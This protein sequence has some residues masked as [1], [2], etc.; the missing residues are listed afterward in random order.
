MVYPCWILVDTGKIGTENQAVGL[1][2]RLGWPFSVHPI[3]LP[4]LA[5]K[6][7]H[8]KYVQ[9]LECLPYPKIIIAAGRRSQPV[10]T[11]FK[12]YHP[13]VFLIALLNP[14]KPLDLFDLV[15]APE[16][17]KLQ[18]SNV[19]ST[20]G[21]LHRITE[22]KL[23]ESLQQENFPTLRRPLLGV[24][25]GGVS[26]HY[27]WTRSVTENLAAHFPP[28][29]PLT[30][31]RFRVFLDAL[32]SLDQAGWGILVLP[33]RRTPPWL[34][35][36][37]E[38]CAQETNIIIKKGNGA[39]NPYTSVLAASDA[40]LVTADSVSMI[41]EACATRKPVYIFPL[42][43][44]SKKLSALHA[45]FY[46]AERARP[47]QGFIE[48]WIPPQEDNTLEATIIEKV[49]SFFCHTQTA[50]GY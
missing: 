17:D 25:M 2:E 43:G 22:T 38:Q 13:E 11:L 35:Q 28:F 7:L 3:D 40:L 46:K 18:G 8:K 10:A 44:F 36:E 24:L 30:I 15:I 41:S 27:S 4:C 5:L 6:A 21:V 14:Q 34:I 20:L 16:H 31:L 45:A 1:A 49:E 37:L 9:R 42:S 29:I 19:L 26:K 12:K 32:R 39:F 48:H 23:K 50:T 33:S 47:F